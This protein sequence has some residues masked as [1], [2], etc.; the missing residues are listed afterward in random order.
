M[1]LAWYLQLS[2]AESSWAYVW[3]RYM[4]HWPTGYEQVDPMMFSKEETVIPCGAVGSVAPLR[5]VLRCDSW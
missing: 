2:A 4:E 1:S 5:V 3:H